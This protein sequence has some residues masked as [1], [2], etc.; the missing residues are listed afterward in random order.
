MKLLKKRSIA[1]LALL[2]VFSLAACAVTP[3]PGGQSQP[4]AS[5]DA[6]PQE[7]SETGA[8]SDGTDLSY[9]VFPPLAGKIR[10]LTQEVFT[11]SRTKGAVSEAFTK[12][13]ADFALNLLKKC[14]ADGST[15]I[16]PLSILTALQMAANG[17]KGETLEEMAKVLCAMDTE[18]LNSQLFNYYESLTNTENA[19]LV[20]ANAVW[21]TD[22]TDFHVSKDYVGVIDNTFR[23]DVA[24]AP[25][26]E[27]RTVDEINDW[28]SRNTDGMIEKILEHGSLSNETI[29]VLL[30]AI[31]FD[32]HWETT[33]EES[34]VRDAVFHGEKQKK[35]IKMMYSREYGYISGPNETGFVKTYADGHYA[36]VGL[37]PNGGKTVSAYLETL[38]GEKWVS[39]MRSAGGKVDAG[40][41]KFEFDWSG[42][43]PDVLRSL[44]MRKVFTA[45]QSDLSGLGYLDSGNGIYISEVIHKTHI[46]VDE[47]GTRAAAVTAVVPVEATA[48]PAPVPQV[49]LD[50]P[51]VYA[52]VDT[53][54][55]LPVFI[56]TMTD[57]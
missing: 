24:V 17:A 35:N 31:C 50:R 54:T 8:S 5:Q 19:S 42:S 20:P 9:D 55:N 29:M 27:D 2:F 47:S 13:Y 12:G 23:A 33:Y 11:S 7:D 43:L 32:A 53:H 38:D 34:D 51:F 16:S 10:F 49:Y 3:V 30:N 37:L 52:I 15:L 4:A 25:M 57:F 44:G 40:L 39:L 41:P 46:E 45:D 1:A 56:G 28:C 36:F 18:E 14:A 21:M 6:Q 26:S 22:R 48:V